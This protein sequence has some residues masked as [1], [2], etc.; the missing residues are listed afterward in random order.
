MDVVL[1]GRW[2][3]RGAAT[4]AR[5]GRSCTWKTS[6]CFLAAFFPSRGCD[7]GTLLTVVTSYEARLHVW[8]EHAPQCFFIAPAVLTDKRSPLVLGLQQ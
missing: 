8:R 5:E 4:T 2:V 1:V 3:R 6:E 7:C